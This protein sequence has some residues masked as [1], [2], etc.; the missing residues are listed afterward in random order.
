MKYNKGFAPIIILLIILGVL[1]VGG[2]A[3]FAG[4]SSAPKNEVTDNSNYFPMTEQNYTPPTTNN[5]PPTQTPPPSN[6]PPQQQTPPPPQQQTGFISPTQGST[7]SL[8]NSMAIKIKTSPQW[9]HCSNSFYLYNSSNQEVGTVGILT[10]QG[11]TVYSWPDVSKRYA[12]CGTGVGEIPISVSAGTYKICLKEQNTETGIGNNFYCSGLFTINTPISQ[13]PP[14]PSTVNSFFV[15]NA[16]SGINVSS[17]TFTVNSN[18]YSS[19][20]TFLAYMNTLS[21]GLYNV[22]ISASGY[23]PMAGDRIAVPGNLNNN[24]INLDP[25]T[26]AHNCPHQPSNTNAFALC[27]Y[28]ADQNHNALTGVQV[29]SPTFSSI[30]AVTASD[31]YYDTQFLPL[32]NY[33]CG[34]PVTFTYSKSGYKTLNYILNGP[35]I[36]I[37]GDMGTQLILNHGSGTEQ[38]TDKHGM[39]P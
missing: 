5:N 39:C 32:Q 17:P 20:N 14:Q 28:L 8:G 31:G 6:N 13:Q 21:S 33:D 29:S 25:V 23:Q 2:V 7:W 9:F 26:H 34:N 16:D 38:K 22:N 19:I 27:G 24:I 37:G 18:T 36:Y 35:Y 12:T 11:K 3:Y 4:K 1:A 30:S 10:E 15:V